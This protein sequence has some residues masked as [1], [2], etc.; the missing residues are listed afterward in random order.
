MQTKH[1]VFAL[2]VAQ[3]S[4]L[5]LL[6][7]H[8]RSSPTAGER[9]LV[10]VA[11]LLA[12]ALKM[13]LCVAAMGTRAP[14]ELRAHLLVRWRETLRVAV[15][16][17]LYTVQ[18]YLLFVAL[19]HLD[20]G[21]FQ[22]SYQLKTLFTALFSVVL[23]GKRL[24]RSQWL[25]LLVLSAGVI[26]VQRPSAAPPA[27]SPDARRVSAT[28]LAAVVAAAASSGFASV[29]FEKM[30]KSGGGA[31]LWVR[32][33]QLG[34]FALPAAAATALVQDGAAIRARGALAG[35]GA[36]AM[37]V[38]VL[39]AAGGLLVAAVVKYADNLVKTFATV[40]SIL[41]S[42]LV[43][44]PL[45]GL[46]PSVGL[47]QGVALVCVSVV[48]YAR[49]AAPVTPPLLDGGNGG[50]GGAKAAAGGGFMSPPLRPPSSFD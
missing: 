20:A 5:V 12:E 39:N 50:G 31:S 30:L 22:V 32:N 17:L 34:V 44:I 9:Y 8:S 33:V 40:I 47:A 36:S 37:G 4:S 35:F 25:G 13:L 1:A 27:A 28:G 41:L 26:A 16:A 43:S 23:L 15:P 14:R 45:F 18:N 2:L 49:P 29:Y 46:V 24:G 6:M 42:A 48:L 19:T 21:T 38:V 7:R 10:S 11:V 3:N